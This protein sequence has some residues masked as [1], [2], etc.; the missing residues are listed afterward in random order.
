MRENS[1]RQ[2]GRENERVKDIQNHSKLLKLDKER[3]RK[4]DSERKTV[5][6]KNEI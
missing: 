2:R 5:K 1:G 4:K 3:A 6:D